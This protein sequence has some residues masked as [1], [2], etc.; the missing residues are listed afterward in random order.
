MARSVDEWIGKNDD[1]RIPD[2]VKL[3]VIRRSNGR[4]I[5]CQ[6]A[7]DLKL[8][9]QMD[10]KV[11]LING[12]QHRESNLVAACP[13]CHKMKTK[14]DRR[15]QAESERYERKLYGL[16]K[17]K[18]RVM[19]GTKRSHLKKRLDGVVIDRRTGKPVTFG[20]SSKED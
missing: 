16:E 12:G 9:A 18:G 11:A 2:K 8:P 4:C 10:H 6:R 13:E 19:P 5:I 3:R 14:D 17:P 20:R 7:F 1:E 15:K